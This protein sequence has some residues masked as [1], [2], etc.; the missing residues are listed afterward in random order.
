MY[1]YTRVKG[2][3][4]LNPNSNPMTPTLKLV[5]VY[6]GGYVYRGSKFA[7]VLGGHYIFADHSTG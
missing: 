1:L 6:P 2:N 3:P 5:V 7:D 4:N